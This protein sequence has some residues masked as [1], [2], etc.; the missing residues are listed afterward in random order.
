MTGNKPNVII[1]INPTHNSSAAIMVDGKIV[2]ACQEERFSRLKNTQSLPIKS[3][4]Y[5]LNEAGLKISDVTSVVIPAKGDMPF[6]IS[7]LED[8]SIEKS[9]ELVK[10][11]DFFRFIRYRI[12]HTGAY[13]FSGLSYLDYWMTLCLN[14]LIGPKFRKD[15]KNLLSLYCSID[16]N[17]VKY[18]SHHEAH[19]AFSYYGSGFGKK[20]LKTLVFTAD[21]GGG[22]LSATVWKARGSSMKLISKTPIYTSLAQM[23]MFTTFYLGLKP[24]EDEY[25]VMGLAPYANSQKVDRLLANILKFLT[26]DKK[27]LRFKSEKTTNIFHKEMQNLFGGQRFD[28]IAGAIQKFAEIRI[29]EWISAAI[30]RY[31][32]NSLTAGGGIFANVKINKKIAELDETD[33]I[34]FAPSPG[35]ESNAIGACYWYFYETHPTVVPEPLDNLYLGP[36]SSYFDVL[37]TLRR[38]KREGFEVIHSKDINKLVAKRLSEGHIIARYF[39]RMEFGSRALGNRSILA[40]PSNLEVKDEL[41]RIIKSRDFW[42][43]FAPSVIDKYS[44]KYLVN[45]KNLDSPYMMLAFETTPLA[46]I[47]LVAAIHPYDKSARAQIVTKEGNSDYYDLLMQFFK[48]TGRYGLLNTSLNIHGEPVVCSTDDALSTLKRSG[49][50]FLQLENYLIEKK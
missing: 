46:Q 22:D 36:S 38:A 20:N 9:S 4:N 30:A 17:I 32:I 39:G 11:N 31:K 29:N 1:G 41:N 44:H 7:I 15:Y 10:L 26:V 24:V 19:A 12:L 28:V 40:D 23:Y 16:P 21:G 6:Y 37:K 43:P 33:K 3:I 13:Y 2:A 50:K 49:L 27:S 48:I 42:M 18:V 45:P 35:D 47:D 5:C 14:H 25:K 34:F 8:S